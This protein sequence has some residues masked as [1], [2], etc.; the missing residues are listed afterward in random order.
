MPCAKSRISAIAAGPRPRHP[1]ARGSVRFATAGRAADARGQRASA[2][3]GP[4]GRAGEA[5]LGTV[6]EITL[7]AGRSRSAASTTRAR[8]ARM[9]A[10]R[11]R[12]SASNARCSRARPRSGDLGRPIGVVLEA[13]PVPIT[14]TTSPSRTSGVDAAT[15]A[16]RRR[17]R[18]TPR[19]RRAAHRRS[20]RRARDRIAEQRSQAIC[21]R[22]ASVPRAR[23]STIAATRIPRPTPADDAR[24]R[25]GAR[26]IRAIARTAHA[27][28]SRP[29]RRRSTRGERSPPQSMTKAATRQRQGSTT[30]AIKR[31]DAGG[32]RATRRHDMT[33]TTAAQAAASTRPTVA[34]RAR[35]RARPRGRAGSAGHAAQAADETPSERWARARA[36]TTH[37]T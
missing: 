5:L 17:R 12:D 4:R 24:S 16:V 20:G 14:A 34:A 25:A 28:W 10:K 36:G 1:R 29:R 18:W 19:H 23:S 26:A 22:P 27:A 3:R 31:L 30:G 15:G 2:S 33:T 9:S 37:E 35:R 7:E 13:S 21:S 32:R 8:D 6:V 11:A